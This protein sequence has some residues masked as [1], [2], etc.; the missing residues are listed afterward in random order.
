[1]VD[2]DTFDFL[3]DSL[4]G[5]DT[6]AELRG[7]QSVRATFKLTDHCIEA[8]SIVAA[9]LGIKQKSLFDHLFQD[10]EGLS[11][12]ARRFRDARLQ[13]SNRIQKTYVISRNALLSLEDIAKSF[14]A[15]RD[16]LIEYSVQRL[17]PIIAKE[18]KRHAKRKALFKNIQRH[19]EAGRKL[20]QETYAELGEDDP[21][22][23]RMAAAM[24]VYES[25]FKHME[26]FIEKSKSIEGFEPEPTKIDIVFED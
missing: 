26:A 17:L 19:L 4:P 12:I 9:Q 3:D 1:M 16:V 7:R 5:G 25:A 11:S 23:D 20:L 24:G 14:N 13:A 2:K 8:I 15:P 6:M 18:R 21:L 22:T 10:T